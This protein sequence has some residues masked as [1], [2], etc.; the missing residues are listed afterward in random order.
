MQK[1]YYDRVATNIS[2][3]SLL[4]SYMEKIKLDQQQ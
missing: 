3:P 2:S 1:L 4:F